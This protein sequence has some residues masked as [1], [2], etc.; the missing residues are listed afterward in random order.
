MRVLIAEDEP[1]IADAVVATLHQQGHVVDHVDDG[2]QADA[3]L[4]STDYQ[5]LVLDLGLLGNMDGVRVLQRL[6]ER[7]ATT[8]VLVISAREALHERV[9]V[10]DLG[11]DDYLVKPFALEEFQAR[12]R[13]VLRRAISK[14]TPELRLGRLRLDL[15]G[16]RAWI[17]MQALELTAREYGLLGALATRADRV[18]NRAQLVEA[19]CGW[20]E[21]ISDN[22]LDIAMHRLRRKLHG[23]GV[24]I[25]TIRGLGYLLQECQD[26]DDE[27]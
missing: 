21:D 11:A 23:S 8:P 19:L 16:R 4:R 27:G 9:R 26:G 22:G 3:A 17:D 12:V 14:G 6:R 1:S 10:L 7:G 18:T 5:L 24:G 2:S 20:D 15:T 25:R 13:S